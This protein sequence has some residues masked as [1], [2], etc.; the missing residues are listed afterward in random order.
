MKCGMSEYERKQTWL[1]MLKRIFKFTRKMK[2]VNKLQNQNS[3]NIFRTPAGYI[4]V[5]IGVSRNNPF[6]PLPV[7]NPAHA[8]E[9]LTLNEVYAAF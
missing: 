5:Y 4:H 7:G 2:R 1:E 9:C 8:P 3:R 6:W